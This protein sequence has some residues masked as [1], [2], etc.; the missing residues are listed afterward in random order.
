MVKSAL[1]SI[2]ADK[3]SVMQLSYFCLLAILLLSSPFSLCA[4]PLEETPLRLFV[5][6]RD[7]STSADENFFYPLLHLALSKTE[8]TDGPFLIAYYPIEQS[9]ARI[10]QRLKANDGID[11]IWTSTNKY[12]ED[13]FLFVPFSLLQ[14]LSDYRVFLIRSGN[15]AKFDQVKNIDDLRRLPVGIGGHWPDAKLLENNG[16]TIVTSIYYDL[17]FKMLAAGRFEFFPR[18]LFEVWDDFEKY[19]SL[20]ISV[21]TSLMLKYSAPFYFFVRKDNTT[22]ADRIGRGLRIAQADGSYDQLL[23]SLEP[24]RRGRQALTDHKRLVFQLEEKY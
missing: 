5:P 20:G 18:A 23:M 19:Q 6:T 3:I 12:R 14:E 8:S 21:E 2:Q 17:L 22:L 7:V 9:S 16:F 10:L 15:Q 4:Q 1:K 11:V 13:E 24:F